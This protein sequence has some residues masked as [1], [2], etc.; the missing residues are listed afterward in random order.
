MELME[1]VEKY[2]AELDDARWQFPKKKYEN[3]FV[4]DYARDMD[5][6]HDLDQ[7]LASW[8]QSLIGM[9]KWMVE[10]CRVDIITEVSMMASQMSMP[11]EG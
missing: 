6:T 7:E 9:L 10:I 8:Y 3:C 4:E 2:L 11:R 5:K 1:N